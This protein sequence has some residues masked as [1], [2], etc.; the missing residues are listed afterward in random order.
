[1]GTGSNTM[2]RPLI[3]A[4]LAVAAGLLA[5]WM[6]PMNAAAEIYKWTD[7]GGETHYTQTPPPSGTAAETVEGAPPP[8]EDPE[9]I[10]Q[11]L[12][13]QL[14]AYDDAKAVRDEDYALQKKHRETLEIIRKNC[15]TARSNLA[16]LQQGGRKRY[17]TAD[18]EVQYLSEEERNRRIEEAEGQIREFCK[19]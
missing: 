8:A 3:S 14:D 19:E 10:R 13:E 17:M 18:G 9:K 7:P 4:R 16:N 1:M 5:S 12:Q 15:K 2:Q 6:L 11:N